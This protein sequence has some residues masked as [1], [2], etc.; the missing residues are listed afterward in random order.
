MPL[1]NVLHA[2][3]ACS[4]GRR[5]RTF[6]RKHNITW[7]ESLP[8]WRRITEAA[9]KE[10]ENFVGCTALPQMSWTQ[11]VARGCAFANLPSGKNELLTSAF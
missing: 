8:H 11:R 5:V 10:M 4:D 7:Y 6:V 3:S 1:D 2:H 9:V